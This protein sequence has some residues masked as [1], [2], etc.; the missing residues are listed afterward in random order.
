[1]PAGREDIAGTGTLHPVGSRKRTGK[2]VK[3]KEMN[4][5]C[6]QVLKPQ[7]P[8]SHPQTPLVIHFLQQ[9]P[10]REDSQSFPDRAIS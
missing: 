6:D 8:P 4:R 2:A 3:K 7:G 1:M 5:K 9:S 10:F